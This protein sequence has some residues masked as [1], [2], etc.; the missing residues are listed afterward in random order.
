[1]WVFGKET[2]KSRVSNLLDDKMAAFYI[3]ASLACL[4]LAA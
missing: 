3:T 1:M 4:L 2:A